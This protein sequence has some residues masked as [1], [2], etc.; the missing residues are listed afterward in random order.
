MGKELLL[1]PWG[2]S[3]KEIL[4]IFL[5]N[6]FLK[7]N[8]S[9][10]KSTFK[11]FITVWILKFQARLSLTGLIVECCPDIIKTAEEECCSKTDKRKN[12]VPRLT[13]EER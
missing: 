8:L 4:E 6:Y 11:E 1:V 3:M 10:K 9:N 7:I 12:V 5:I 2:N 13:R